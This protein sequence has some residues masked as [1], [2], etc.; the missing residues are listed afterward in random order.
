M[1][2]PRIDRIDGTAR[3]MPI[4]LGAARDVMQQTVIID[5]VLSVPTTVPR[6]RPVGVGD[7]TVYGGNAR[8]WSD[9]QR[10]TEGC[11]VMVR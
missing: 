3:L 8:R 5:H 7:P 11:P 6:V 9:I 1:V 4:C 10:C 2:D